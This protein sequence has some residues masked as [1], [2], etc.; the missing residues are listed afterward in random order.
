MTE[1][2]LAE[3]IVSVVPNPTLNRDL[4]TQQNQQV[5]MIISVIKQIKSRYDLA[6]VCL[7]LYASG[8]MDDGGKAALNTLKELGEVV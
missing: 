5:D 6:T 1:Q 4:R 7:S 8:K 3:K 2:E